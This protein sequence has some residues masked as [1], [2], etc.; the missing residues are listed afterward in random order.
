V[1]GDDKSDD[2]N[3]EAGNAVSPRPSRP[4]TSKVEP[5]ACNDILEE[6]SITSQNG[7]DH[8]AF[9]SPT[10]RPP[11]HVTDHGVEL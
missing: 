7:E 10:E 2:E 5:I 1:T 6:V 3:D 4:N 11:S 9:P 8:E